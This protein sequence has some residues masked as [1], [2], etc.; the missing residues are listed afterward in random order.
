MIMGSI[1]YSIYLLHN[2]F[3][4]LLLKQYPNATISILI[5]FFMTIL[6]SCFTYPFWERPL[7]KLGVILCQKINPNK[8]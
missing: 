3:P 4:K 5:S 1:S 6:F 2:L 8:S 7:Q